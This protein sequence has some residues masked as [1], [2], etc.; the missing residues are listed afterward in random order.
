M[1]IRDSFSRVMDLFF[2]PLGI[3][4]ESWAG[5]FFWSHGPLSWTPRQFFHDFLKTQKMRNV[6][7]INL[8][9]VSRRDLHYVSE[10]ET[11]CFGQNFWISRSRARL[12]LRG[13]GWDVG[14]SLQKMFQI[15]GICPANYAMI[16]L[17]LVYHGWVGHKQMFHAGHRGSRRQS[18]MV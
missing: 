5:Q 11:F 12:G 9:A 3:F 10:N 18:K 4:L 17:I 7:T 8:A 16:V 6:C 14:F 2:G 13:W 1:C 15:R